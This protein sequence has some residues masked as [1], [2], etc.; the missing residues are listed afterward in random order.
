[1]VPTTLAGKTCTKQGVYNMAIKVGINGFGRIGRQVYKAIYENYQGVLDVEAVNDL[2]DVKTSAHL[3]T[4]DSSY[5]RFPGHVE[6]C[7][8]DIHVDGQP[9]Q[10]YASRQPAPPPCAALA[11]GHVPGCSGIVRSR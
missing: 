7:D 5:G 3:L 1:M 8:G 2:T 6:A 10:S 9:L 4:Y 11:V